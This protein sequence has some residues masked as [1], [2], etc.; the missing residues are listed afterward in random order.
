MA[1]EYA[2]VIR[3]IIYHNNENGY[4]VAVFETES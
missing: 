2:G 4:T 1:E 3:E